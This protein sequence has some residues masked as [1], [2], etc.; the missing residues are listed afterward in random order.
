MSSVCS[1]GYVLAMSSCGAMRSRWV[2]I[3]MS[4]GC[5][6]IAITSCGDCAAMSSGGEDVAMSSCIPPL[7]CLCKVGSILSMILSLLLSLL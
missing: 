3:A 1:S 7:V 2:I 6:D 4:S 5:G